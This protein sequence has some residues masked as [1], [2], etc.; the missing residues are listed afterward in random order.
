[1]LILGI[2]AALSAGAGAATFYVD[3]INGSD[4]NPGSQAAPWRT[5]A[6]VNSTTKAGDTVSFLAGGVWN[7]A[8]VPVSGTALSLT[9]YAS[10]GTGSK[11]KIKGLTVNNKAYVSVNGLEIWND[12][13]NFPVYI[14]GGSNHISVRN[15]TIWASS[16]CG[17]WAAFYV[18]N[19]NYNDFEYNTVEHQNLA[20]QHD[21][22]ALDQ[23][24][25]YNIIKNNTT[26]K[27]SH[28][29]LSI[30]GA[31]DI[32][33][34]WS[35]SYNYIGYNTV[36]NPN[37]SPAQN[38]TNANN[39]IIEYNT[40]SGGG[41]LDS[42]PTT[43]KLL[44]SN[45]VF[46]YNILKDMPQGTTNG[47]GLRLE[48]YA[49]GGNW[50]VN[51]A[52]YNHVYGNIITNIGG[53]EG[54]NGAIYI[55]T[56]DTTGVATNAYNIF[57]NNIVF[58]NLLSNEITRQYSPLI[59]DNAFINNIIYRS[60]KTNIIYTDGAARTVS[61]A[62]LYEPTLWQGNVQ[63]DPMLDSSLKPLQGS[64]A[65]ESGAHLT[66]I[67]SISG[68]GTSLAVADPRYFTD[69]MGIVSG[70]I[71]QIGTQTAIIIAIN[72]ST[73]VLTLDRT[74]TWTQGATISLP[75]KGTKPDIGIEKNITVLAPPTGLTV[76]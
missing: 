33:P 45:N 35:S 40:F 28:Y 11:P 56:N 75:Y 13:S 26:G 69:G 59:H 7:E 49:Y 74:V 58:N 25:S 29:S 31:S 44:G 76:N 8:L 14:Y 37:G 54:G 22:F 60:N 6:K 67:T 20:S 57:K 34:T 16:S 4:A 27:A 63:S 61:G 17:W 1:M 21:A 73:K 65:L 24:C 46:R 39:N 52:M 42:Y 2:L 71:I 55:G 50:P 23:G 18:T 41:T 47:R 32:N 53:T 48:T 72:Y 70:D 66:T 9:T 5:V 62:Q 3:A 30:T 12:N 38:Y 51:V 36:N 10:Y 68:S 64:P 19:A 43:F 15:C